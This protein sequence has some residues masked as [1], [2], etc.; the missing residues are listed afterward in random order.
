MTASSAAG[1]SARRSRSRRWV[2]LL[3]YSGA[4]LI[5]SYGISLR[6]AG[7]LLGLMFLAY[8]PGSLLFR[9]FIDR[10]ARRLIVVLG[11]SAGVVAA[12]IGVA[13]PALW[14]TMPLLA[15]YV[16]LNSGR[17][18]AGSALGLDVAPGRSVTAMGMRASATQVGYL[19]GAGLGGLALHF[20][21]YAAAG[22][23]FA[24]LYVLAVVPH[25]IL[26]LGRLASAGR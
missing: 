3:V 18:L 8:F 13:R 11:L 9:R 17:T 21:G 5:D 25:A 22:A 10:S 16:F 15:T 6:L 7:L 14:L 12:L 4:L 2:G 24:A 20:G 23:T 19:V 26:A 1:G